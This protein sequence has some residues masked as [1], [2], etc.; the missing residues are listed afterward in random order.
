[1]ASSKSMQKQDDNSRT[2][3]YIPEPKTESRREADAKQNSYSFLQPK[4]YNS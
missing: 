3:T 1:M 2:A 4:H